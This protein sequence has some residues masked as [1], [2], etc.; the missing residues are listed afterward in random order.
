[1]NIQFEPVRR[2]VMSVLKEIRIS[3]SLALNHRGKTP[4]FVDVLP[5]ASDSP[6]TTAETFNTNESLVIVIPMYVETYYSPGK[7]LL[8]SLHLRA[9]RV[10]VLARIQETENLHHT[11][12]ALE[13]AHFDALPHQKN[14]PNAS[15]LR[16]QD[17]RSLVNAVHD[18]LDFWEVYASTT[19][20]IAGDMFPL[21]NCT[22]FSLL[23]YM[24]HRGFT[25]N[26]LGGKRTWPHLQ[27]YY[28]RVHERECA[29]RAPPQGW[30]APGGA[31]IFRT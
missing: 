10:L 15:R 4:V 19:R 12:D 3:D 24:V 5:S 11:Y 30:D 7:L 14:N 8:P 23:G 9:A 29:K 25:W 28:L 27:A 2:M 16:N 6:Y 21:A 18:E 1:Q 26:R 31:N 20:Y 13:D 22:F 17:R